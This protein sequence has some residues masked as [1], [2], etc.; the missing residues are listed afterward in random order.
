MGI[1]I[2]GA[3]RRMTTICAALLIGI[4]GSAHATGIAQI[5]HARQNHFHQLGRTANSLRDQIGQSRPN[6]A[7]LTADANLIDHLASALPSWF[8]AGSGKG[9]GVDTRARAAI[10]IHPREFAKFA[11]QILRRAQNLKQAIGSRDLGAARLRARKL[12]Q[13]CDSCHRRFRGNSSL[14]RMW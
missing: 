14:W 1:R 3:I 6:W 2:D 4:A 8:P 12:G 7:V 9:H 5:I 10:W 13:G 11:R